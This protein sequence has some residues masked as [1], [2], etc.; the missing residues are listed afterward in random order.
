MNRIA[1]VSI[2]LVLFALP[3]VAQKKKTAVKTQ[4]DKFKDV[5][6]GSVYLGDV[7]PFR[8]LSG[9]N[10]A[11]LMDA[12]YCSSGQKLERPTII[13]IRLR[14]RATTW[15]AGMR[16]PTPRVIFLL[17]NN[18]RL[19]LQGKYEYVVDK[20]LGALSQITIAATADEVLKIAGAKTAEFQI[21]GEG[22]KLKQNNLAKLKDLAEN[23]SP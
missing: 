3:A 6:C 23:G 8:V 9:E 11:V 5:T 21:S 4:Y 10:A 18:D 19:S 7:A 16:D 13:E 15:L 14:S 1:T 20:V 17:D 22:Y 12:S 2:M